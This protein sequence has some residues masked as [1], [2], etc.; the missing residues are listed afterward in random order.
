M[1]I[2]LYIRV[3]LYLSIT[4]MLKIQLFAGLGNQLFMIFATISYAIDHG[5][6][7]GIISYMDKTLDGPITYWDTILDSFKKNVDIAGSDSNDVYHEPSFEYNS[8]PSSLSQK[9]S[10]MKGYFQSYR[11]FEHNYEQIIEIMGLREKQNKIREEYSEL[12][13]GKT[14][15]MHFRFG[16][17]IALQ[18]YHCVKKPVY[19]IEAVNSLSD[20]LHAIGENIADY[21]ILYFCQP[22]NDRYVCDFLK[23]ILHV[24]SKKLN[25]VRVPDDIPDWKQ[26]LLMSCC[27]HFVITNSTFSWFGAYFSENRNKIVYRPQ[28]WFGPA[29]SQKDTSDI[30]PI[31]WKVINE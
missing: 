24:S 2:C 28:K 17:Y 4:N 22:G 7:Y 10:I 8:L 9:E 29:N 11:Y 26:M 5:I 6:K 27:N 31:E 20:D 16:D 14:I 25:F 15:A 1:K 3:E 30:C 13:K 23:I 19:F 21:K 12:L 18:Q